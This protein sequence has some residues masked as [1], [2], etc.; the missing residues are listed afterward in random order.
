MKG[1]NNV[2]IWG[3]EIRSASSR[4]MRSPLSREIDFSSL[5]PFSLSSRWWWNTSLFDW[6][7]NVEGAPFFLASYWV[8]ES[9]VVEI[10]GL[11]AWLFFVCWFF[12][13]FL[14]SNLFCLLFA[15][16]FVYQ[17]LLHFCCCFVAVCCCLGCL[18]HLTVRRLFFS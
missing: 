6:N 9:K 14:F 4:K 1:K 8:E 3:C 11:N 12:C 5:V 18:L 7:S 10:I 15:F 2:R 17:R 13:Y 16:V